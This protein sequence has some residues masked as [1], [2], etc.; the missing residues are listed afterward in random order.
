MVALKWTGSSNDRFPPQT[1]V[2]R[3]DYESTLLFSKGGIKVKHEGSASRPSSAT[4]KGT[5]YLEDVDE[6]AAEFRN[7]IIGKTAPEDN[8]W[9][10]M[11]LPFPI[12]MKRLFASA[13]QPAFA[14]PIKA[15]PIILSGP[16][17]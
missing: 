4:V 17:A 7:E 6:I 15:R 13:G 1:I 14:N 3:R 10:C 12:L 5:R 11:N 9:A 16:G 2:S 8:P